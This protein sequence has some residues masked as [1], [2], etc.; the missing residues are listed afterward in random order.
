MPIR[1]TVIGGG[2]GGCA[3]A[4]EAARNGA[5]VTLVEA[6]RLGGTC[7]HEGCIPTKTLKRSAEVLETVRGAGAFGV[8]SD[9]CFRV[10]MTAVLA[11][12][13]AVRATLL[14]GLEKT[15]ARL[16]IRL[17]RG[18]GRVVSADCVEVGTDGGMVRVEGDRV[19]LATGSAERELP[20]LAFDHERI[21]S[22]ADMLERENIP[23]RLIILGGGVIGCELAF[24]FRS[25]GSEVI[26]VEGRERVLPLPSVDADIS[27]LLLREMKKRKIIVHCRSTLRNIFSEGGGIR[28]ELTPFSFVEEKSVELQADAVLV[29]VGRIPRTAGLGLEDAGIRTKGGWIVVDEE[30][31]TSVPG[32]YAVGDALGPDK[33]MLAHVAEAEGVCAA[34]NCMGGRERMRHDVIPSAIFTSPESASVGLTE[35]AACAEGRRIRTA[36]FQVREL[37]KAQVM[38]ELAGLCKLVADADTGTLLGAH[39]AGP[40]AADLV[41]EAALALRAGLGVH[42]LVRTIHAHPTLAEGM[43]ETARLLE[44][45]N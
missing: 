24:I 2:P 34:H 26:L 40:H 18:K 45:A 33:A 28:A 29:T 4:F 41:A 32:I 22:S 30:L 20:G 25:F 7:L 35:D 21:L 5:E 39:L 6:D 42:D 23:S 38:G 44:A 17:L 15:C 12:K 19:I 37:G 13:T 43:R 3:A 10:D 36:V 27:A 16:G 8:F 9:G 14:G 31:R 1:L 11:R